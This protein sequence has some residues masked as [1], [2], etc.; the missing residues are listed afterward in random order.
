MA[1]VCVTAKNRKS[2]NHSRHTD[3]FICSFAYQA[4]MAH[5]SKCVNC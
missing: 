5:K 4:E 3:T 2:M 1:S